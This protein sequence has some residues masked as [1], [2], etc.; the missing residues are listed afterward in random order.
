M[1]L[2]TQFQKRMKQ[3]MKRKKKRQR[4]AAKGQNVNDFLYG[5]FYLK[6]PSSEAKGA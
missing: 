3:A 2:K 4:L 1:G 5:R 6:T